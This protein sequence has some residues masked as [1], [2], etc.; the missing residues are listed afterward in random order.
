[1]IGPLMFHRQAAAGRFEMEYLLQ[2]CPYPPASYKGSGAMRWTHS[3]VCGTAG[4]KNQGLSSIE[5]MKHGDHLKG[6]QEV[7]GGLVITGRDPSELLDPVEGI[8]DQ[9]ARP[10]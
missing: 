1:M 8:L 2:L 10:V 3:G 7:P 5:P 9:M 6:G 4:K